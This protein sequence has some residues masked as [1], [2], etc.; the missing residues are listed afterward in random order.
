MKESNSENIQVGSTQWY[1]QAAEQIREDILQA[2]RT[3]LF[4]CAESGYRMLLKEFTIEFKTYAFGSVGLADI[5]AVSILSMRMLE[6]IFK[7]LPPQVQKKIVKQV[8]QTQGH[9]PPTRP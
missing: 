4:I 1:K 3:R 6:K 2:H 8:K 7:K 5:V 9:R